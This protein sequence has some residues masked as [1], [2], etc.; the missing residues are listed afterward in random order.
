MKQMLTVALA[1]VVAG[2]LVVAQNARD[3]QV[4]FKAAQHT[5]EVQGD[6][7]AAIAQYQHVVAAGNRALAA[8]ALLRMAAC[9]E[10]LGGG[11]S[12]AI[13]QRV[14]RDYADQ[15]DPVAVARERLGR[16][17]PAGRQD[18]ASRLRLALAPEGD[19][20]GSAI[21][22]DGRFL[23]YTDWTSGGDLVLRK[24]A[25]GRDRRLTD[26]TRR[27]GG[28]EAAS[29][30]RDGQQVAYAWYDGAKNNM[31]LRVA[32]LAGDGVPESRLVYDNEDVGSMY[33][34]DW[35]P[36]GALIAV[37]LTRADN[38]GQMGLVSVRNGSLRVLKSSA[39]LGARQLFFS[40]DGKHMG[41][42]LPAGDTGNDQRDVFIL[43]G[44]KPRIPGRG[45][46][47]RHQRRRTAGDLRC[48]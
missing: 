21:S 3:P 46:D 26:Q 36:E 42:D 39:W 6:L 27:R 18:M 19:L 31:E 7:K 5:E 17:E 4:L 13:Y 10:K 43:G 16:G 45:E 32:S 25:T 44:R 24:L 11:Q 40:P 30:S 41:F 1:L 47:D 14:V 37:Q 2:T 34:L 22:A 29:M 12:R 9:Y 15:Q 35:S 28:V 20:S 38:T 48:R 8:Q 23:T 33:P